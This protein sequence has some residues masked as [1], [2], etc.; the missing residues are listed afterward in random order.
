[1]YINVEENFFSLNGGSHARNSVS[2]ESVLLIG[3]LWRRS[4]SARMYVNDLLRTFATGRLIK[5]VA[6]VHLLWNVNPL[7]S[8]SFSLSFSFFLCTSS[9]LRE[10]HC[11]Q[12]LKLIA[13]SLDFFRYGSSSSLA[14]LFLHFFFSDLQINQ[15]T[16][17]WLFP[18]PIITTY[19]NRANWTMI[20][21]TK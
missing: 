17:F 20:R 18:E 15:R 5:N 13:N 19:E 9:D 11:K 14:F 1:M 8:F 4:L 7:I 10:F 12:F 2:G 16:N 21:I 6:D 3:R